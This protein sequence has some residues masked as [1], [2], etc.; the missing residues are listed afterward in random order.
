M[1]QYLNLVTAQKV[2]NP[3]DAVLAEHLAPDEEC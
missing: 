3:D 2:P 1:N